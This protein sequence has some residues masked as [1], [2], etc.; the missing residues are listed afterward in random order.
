MDTPD[1]PRDL[2]Q[3]LATLQERGVVEAYAKVSALPGGVSNDVLLVQDRSNRYVVKRPLER[4]RVERDWYADT[5][6]VEREAAAL[7]VMQELTPG[8]V[9]RVVD[10]DPEHRILTLALAPAGWFEWRTALLDGDAAEG[11]IGAALGQILAEWHSRTTGPSAVPAS[12]RDQR[13]FE[14]L[15]ITPFYGAVAEQHPKL[16][17]SLEDLVEDLR[18][19]RCLVHGDFSPKNVL[20][21]PGELWVLDA[22]VAHIGAPVFDLAFMHTHLLLKSVNQPRIAAELADCAD[23]FLTAYRE[24]AP[25]LAQISEQSLVQHIGALLLSRVDGL[26]PCNYLAERTHPQVRELAYAALLEGRNPWEAVAARGRFG[27]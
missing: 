16:R 27:S 19:S 10:F 3:L 7:A 6:R 5:E 2:Q 17:S 8:R 18:C 13:F 24:G 20:I 23:A 1:L 14:E 21:G 4:L 9:P 22:E 26:S 25:D 12:L 11:W 15:R